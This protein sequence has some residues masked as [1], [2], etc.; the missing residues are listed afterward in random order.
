MI[1]KLNKSWNWKGFNAIEVLHEND[2]GN[3]IFKTEKSG[4]WRLCPEEISCLKIANT[5]NELNALLDDAEY[6]ED[7]QMTRLVS[8]AKEELGELEENMK[9]CL[10]MPAVLGGEYDVSNIGKINFQELVSLSGN[11][12]FQIKDIKDGQEIRFD[13][14]N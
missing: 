10:K 4:F 2:F 8:I 9:Y 1:D 11:L 12:G 5:E 13:I 3:I 6:K 7:W 14:T